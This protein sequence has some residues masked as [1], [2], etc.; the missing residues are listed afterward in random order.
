MNPDADV[1]YQKVNL[2]T[3]DK[4]FI[5]FISDVPHYIWWNYLDTVYTILV[6]RPI[7]SI[8]VEQW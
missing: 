1:T 6:L 8:D 2:F 7:H 5:V 4:C 3:S